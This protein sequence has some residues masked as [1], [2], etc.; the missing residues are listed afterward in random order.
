MSVLDD[1]KTVGKTLQE[2]GKIEQYEQIL[3]ARTKMLEMQEKINELKQTNE[4]LQEKLRK[5]G[6]LTKDQ[7]VYFLNTENGKE[8]PLCTRCWEKEQVLITLQDN[9]IGPWNYVCPECNNKVRYK[10]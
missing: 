9:S 8:G 4:G 2:I 7:F 3:D 10:K 5:K 1:L 6:N